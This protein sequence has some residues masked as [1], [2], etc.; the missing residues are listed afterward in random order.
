MRARVCDG[1][2]VAVGMLPRRRA[3]SLSKK[4]PGQHWNSAASPLR[5]GGCK[6]C[7]GESQG[8][9]AAARLY[10]RGQ[11]VGG[12]INELPPRAGGRRQLASGAEWADASGVQSGWILRADACVPERERDRQI[13][14][15]PWEVFQKRPGCCFHFWLRLEGAGFPERERACASPLA[16]PKE[17]ESAASDGVDGARITGGDPGLPRAVGPCSRRATMSLP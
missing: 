6:S 5:A 17:R 7:D 1:H 2:P 10:R 11:A 9:G 8:K 3:R 16:S 14:H 4:R 15:A 12:H 13:W